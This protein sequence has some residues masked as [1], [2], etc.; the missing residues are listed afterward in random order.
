[1]QH[2]KRTSWF[3][4]PVW[5]KYFSW[6]LLVILNQLF[7]AYSSAAPHLL[8]SSD[9]CLQVWGSSLSQTSLWYSKDMVLHIRWIQELWTRICVFCVCMFVVV[10]KNMLPLQLLSAFL[11]LHFVWAV[12]AI[13]HCYMQYF[14]LF[15]SHTIMFILHSFMLL[16]PEGIFFLC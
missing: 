11:T 8:Y 16:M 15:M 6:M 5:R 1:M 4:D 2:S 9:F 14:T 3:K 12:M 7:S 10:E 13:I